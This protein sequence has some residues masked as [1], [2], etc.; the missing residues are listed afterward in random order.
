MSRMVLR[1]ILTILM[2]AGVGVFLFPYLKGEPRSGIVL[3]IAGAATT[4][5]F[6]LLRCFLT[7]GECSERTFYRPNP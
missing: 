4:V 5:I 1:M 7:D 3:L 2:Y 6:G